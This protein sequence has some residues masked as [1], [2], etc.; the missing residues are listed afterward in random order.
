MAYIGQQLIGTFTVSYRNNAG[1][2]SPDQPNPYEYGNPYY[3]ITV[4]P[5]LIHIP[6]NL[7]PSGRYRV[8]RT[9][10]L[11]PSDDAG[12]VKVWDG[13]ATGGTQYDPGPGPVEFNHTSG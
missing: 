4:S 1:G 11:S 8:V 6:Q 12:G 10:I 9:Q 7:T 13:D 3:C 2:C 5:G